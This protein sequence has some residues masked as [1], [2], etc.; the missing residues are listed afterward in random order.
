MGY[1]IR[2]EFSYKP[3]LSAILLNDNNKALK[4]NV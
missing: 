4:A 3:V 2:N 1:I